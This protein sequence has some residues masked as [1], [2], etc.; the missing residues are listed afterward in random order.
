M[1][2]NWGIASSR[3]RVRRHTI[4]LSSAHASAPLPL[5]Y[6][7]P[8]FANGQNDFFQRV[9]DGYLRRA[10]EDAARI[11]VID[12]SAGIEQIRRQLLDIVQ[13]LCP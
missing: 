3:R 11:R 12:A 9:R 13:P 10:R 2:Y 6:L 1:L 7:G 8:G 4:P 5:A